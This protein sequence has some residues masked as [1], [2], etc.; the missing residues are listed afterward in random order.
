[1]SSAVPGMASKIEKAFYLEA[2]HAHGKIR[3]LQINLKGHDGGT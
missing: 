1:M 2:S 3:I